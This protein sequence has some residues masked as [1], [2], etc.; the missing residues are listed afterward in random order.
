MT[1]LRGI[2]AY[3][4][5]FLST[6]ACASA[7]SSTKTSDRII[8]PKMVTRAAM[9]HLRLTPSLVAGSHTY[10]VDIDVLIDS[11]GVPDMS[12]FRATG[13]VAN[14][15]RDAFYEWIRASTFKPA[16]RDGQPISA[17]LHTKIEFRAG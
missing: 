17:V 16:T 5:A 7:G 10:R 3:C 13:P 6:V 8:P 15:N 2:T 4:V 9:P 14:E 11:T 1:R 12:T